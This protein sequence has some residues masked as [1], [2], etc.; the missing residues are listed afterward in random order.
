MYEPNTRR[1]LARMRKVRHLNNRSPR[2]GSVGRN[3]GQGRQR[4]TTGNCVGRSCL[5]ITPTDTQGLFCSDSI[6]SS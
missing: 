3:W 4:H 6:A 5:I 1:C 2:E